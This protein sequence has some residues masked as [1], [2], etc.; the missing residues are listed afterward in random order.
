MSDVAY[1]GLMSRARGLGANDALTLPVFAA[2]LFLSAFLLFSVQPIFTKMVLPKLGGSP[3]VWAVST[4]FFQTVLL[5]GYCYAHALNRFVPLSIAP[6]VHLALVSVAFLALP[7]G[8]PPSSEPPPG[9]AYLWL[10]GVLALGVGLPFFAVSANAPLLQAWFART[11]HPEAND[12]YFL[13]GAS[14]FGSLLALLA[15]PVAIEPVLGLAR[16][17]DGWTAGFALLGGMLAAASLTMVAQ[18]RSRGLDEREQRSMAAARAVAP[19][20]LLQ[21]AS[22]IWYAAVPSGLLVAFTSY[23]S[24]DIASAPFL[25]VVPLAI[26]LATFIVVFRDVPLVSHELMLKLQPVLATIVLCA[27]AS[28][29]GVFWHL[30]I[31]GGFAVFLTT[32]LVCHRELFNR[33][34]DAA[35][36]TEFYLWMSFGGVLGGVFAA[37]VA[38]KLFNSVVEFPLLLLLGLACRPGVFGRLDRHAHRLLAAG[39]IGLL[40][41]L[42]LAWMVATGV[43]PTS[44]LVVLGP[45]LLLAVGMLASLSDARRLVLLAALQV[46]VLVS[47]PTVMNGA[48]S[49]RSFFGVHRVSDRQG[50]R[51]R[52]LMHGTTL[53]GAQRLLDRDGRPVPPRQGALSYYHATSPASQGVEMARRARSAPQDPAAALTPLR[54]GVVGL[55][56]GA[57]ACRSLPGEAWRFFEIDPVVVSI[58]R[59]PARFT[60]LSS[61]QPDADIVVGDARLTLAKEPKASFDYLLIDA[62]SSDAVPVH[63]LTTQAIAMYLDA[64][65]P[66][67]LLALHVSSRHM[68]LDVVAAATALSVAGA[69]V[70]FSPD[71]PDTR[72][73]RDGVASNVVFVSRSQR[74]IEQALARP[75][76]RMIDRAMVAPWTDDYS[77]IVTAIWRHHWGRPVGN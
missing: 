24:T 6:L 32:T 57:M 49:D 30:A 21:R 63:L 18:R 62:F 31:F 61:C 27:V 58:A 16:Q 29:N 12:P 46:V 77:D 68:D 11:G 2:T 23:M 45:S 34:P 42:L 38:P 37:I 1:R 64:L 66:D 51:V 53:H 59:D 40:I 52:V 50:G 73:D 54:V 39:A 75:G 10:V 4:C 33:R 56:A 60:F 26:F 36:L 22:W 70:V 48:N 19:L 17:A 25:W 76:A 72:V 15:Y 41:I 8:L 20:T 14:N 3:S 65:S 43:L 35:R 74:A 69:K 71:R 55:G 28:P 47:M 44:G 5:A 7:F 9:D 67:G 13:Y